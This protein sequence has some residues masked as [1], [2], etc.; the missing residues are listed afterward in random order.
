M[1]PKAVKKVV[2]Y[3][4]IKLVYLLRAGYDSPKMA[5]MVGIQK[6]IKWG[7]KLGKEDRIPYYM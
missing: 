4:N 2:I 1:K 7:G 5:H 3:S 6:I